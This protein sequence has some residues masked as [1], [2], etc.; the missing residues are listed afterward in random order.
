MISRSAGCALA[1][2]LAAAACTDSDPHNRAAPSSSPS[3]P[4]A[5]LAS[6]VEIETA[7]P[8][9]GG[10][11][12]SA[13]ALPRE[14]LL[15]IA[16]GYS[17]ER[18]PDLTVVPRAPNFFGSFTANSHSGPWDYVQRVPIVFY[19]PG[20]IR[21]RGEIE[22]GRVATSADIAPTIAELLDMDWPSDRSSL[23]LS[24]ALLPEEERAGKPR[25][26]V[27]VVWD[28]AGRDVLDQWPDEWPNLQEMIQGGT[29]FGNAV[30]GSSPTVTPAVHASIGTGTFPNRHGIVDIPLRIGDEIVGSWSGDSP[31]Y[32]STATL[33]DLYDQQEGNVPE[34][35]MVGTSEW[36]LGM[37]GH[38][39]Y[40]EGGDHDVALMKSHSGANITNEAYYS[41]PGYLRDLEGFDELV[42]TI[43]T[44]DGQAD[45]RW[46]DNDILDDPKL[47][48]E[49]PA[50][51][52]YQTRV[53]KELLTKDS[54]G[55]DDTTDLLFTN[56][57]Q[58]DYVGH[59]YNMLQPEMR[60]TLRYTDQELGELIEFLD[61]WVGEDRWVMALTA[62]H[63]STPDAEAMKAW[64]ISIS[65]VRA[66]VG[67]PVS[68]PPEEVIEETRVTGFWLNREGI[69]ANGIAPEEVAEFLLDMRVEDNA[70]NV[71]E[72]P[73]GYDRR[74]DE[75]IFSAVWPSERMDDVLDCAGVQT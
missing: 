23:P 2:V 75:H 11:L 62:D 9:R 40:L 31:R 56:Y 20:F 18:S 36:H 25:L 1:L 7:P 17:E 32:L 19:G 6:P 39:A 66:D 16:R 50:A 63:G 54:Y 30:V 8:P 24:N 48:Q 51:T 45:S 12:E 57:K 28:G 61:E 64:P 38:G 42:Q 44:E 21:S 41:L 49:T 67:E 55:R 22:P 70:L 33:A 43:D 53:I 3:E 4:N 71:D 69:E 34:I 29:S 5:G 73:S 52:L 14:Q 37:I 60:E 46:L 10:W 13:C 27:T 74:L 65:E 58:I 26:I 35:A 59:R 68:L 15:F 72:L 47:V